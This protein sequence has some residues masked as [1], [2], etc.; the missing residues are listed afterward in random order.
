MKIP[1]VPNYKL[2]GFDKDRPCNVDG[3]C[4]IMVIYFSKYEEEK[5]KGKYIYA[6]RTDRETLYEML[7]LE[8]FFS[9]WLSI[10]A[11]MDRMKS[12]KITE[13]WLKMYRE[14]LNQT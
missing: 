6:S 13:F 2:C 5:Y 1:N 4:D 9:I 10:S 3:V 14:T 7:P 11:S 12:I 8:R